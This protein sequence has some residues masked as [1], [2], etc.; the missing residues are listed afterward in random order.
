[1]KKKGRRTSVLL[2]LLGVLPVPLTNT[3][4]ASVGENNTA[5]SLESLDLTV[6]R[7]CSTDLLGSRSDGELALE[8]KTVVS[9]LLHN[10]SGA[11]HILVRGVGARADEADPDV[12]G[13]VV[14]LG[15][16]SQLGDRSSKVG[17]ERTVDM[18][19]QLVEVLHQERSVSSI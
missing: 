13:P 19:L 1:M 3:R 17:G 7:N 4:S 9:S 8:A 15:F 14:L 16:L 2:A 5:S 12:I 18:R 11:S 6:T 10:G